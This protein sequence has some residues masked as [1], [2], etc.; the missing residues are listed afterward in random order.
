M[1][2]GRCNVA[3]PGGAS[4]VATIAGAAL[5]LDQDHDVVGWSGVSAGFLVALLAAFGEL[6]QA[7][8][9]MEQ[10]LRR[11]RVLDFN[12]VDGNIGAC[13]WRAIP[14][15]VDDVLGDGVKMGDALV[16][17]YGVVTSADTRE[18]VYLSSKVTPN[19]LVSE[20]AR[21][22][23]A[24]VPLARMVPIPSLG[25]ELSPDVR[26]FF[27]G[28]YVDNLPDDV[29]DFAPA[30]TV[31]V[32]LRHR[33][34]IVRV[35]EGDPLAQ[36]L[37]IAGAVTFAA[38]QRKSRRRDHDGIVVDVDAIGSGFDFDLSINEVRQRIKSGRAGVVAAQEKLAALVG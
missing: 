12:G 16:P 10:F 18:P 27:D 24:I 13:A 23:S 22:T 32:R 8:A 3:L 19:V 14:D 33:S 4:H 31:A 1:S 17:L 7:P 26:L 37:A 9:L 20:V 28:G 6:H 5:Q 36:A 29:F 34:G 35:R 21:A 11:N 30:P 15:L 25:T 2:R 38:C